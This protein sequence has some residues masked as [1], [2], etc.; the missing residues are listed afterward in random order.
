MQVL[1]CEKEDER[2]TPGANLLCGAPLLCDRG[3]SEFPHGLRFWPASSLALPRK[4]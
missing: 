3:D 1:P 2:A 4:T